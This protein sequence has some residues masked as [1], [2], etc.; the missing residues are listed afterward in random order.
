[1]PTTSS[2]T[3]SEPSRWSRS[4]GALAAWLV[5]AAFLIGVAF[6]PQTTGEDGDEATTDI[7]FRYEFAVGSLV[8]YAVIVGLT[9]LVGRSF[10]DAR[11]ALGLRPFPRRWVWIALGVALA[12]LVVS[13]AL[14]PLLPAGEEQGLAPDRWREDRVLAFAL[15][16]V[17]VVLVVPFAEELFFRGLGVRVLAFLGG[18]VAIVGTALVFA[19]SHGILVGIPALG[20]FALGLGWVRYRSE[21]V[22]PGYA[23]HA[24][25][26]GVGIVAAALFALN[27][28]EERQALAFLF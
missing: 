7:L 18:G 10:G 21:S 25:Y 9:W 19:L 28:E 20:F 13:A 24:A 26:N 4:N 2:P 8:V 22:W 1:M 23:A 15:N 27:A 5:L 16:A 14:E 3:S 12:S 17:V 11:E 6:L